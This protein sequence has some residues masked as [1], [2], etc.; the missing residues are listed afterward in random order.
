MRHL[1]C[2]C[3]FLLVAGC[4][5]P[6]SLADDS[7]VPG[8]IGVAVGPDRA[9]VVIT[10]VRPGSSAAHA[11]LRPG[12]VITRYD[13]NRILNGLE[14]ERLLLSSEPGSLAHLEVLR[15]GALRSIDVPVEELAT[16]ESG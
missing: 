2:C 13:G 12:D 11:D 15:A 14:F 5:I 10:A 16:S 3:F 8:T 1:I 7:L 6:P 4:A 9:G